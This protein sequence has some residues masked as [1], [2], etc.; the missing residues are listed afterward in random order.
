MNIKPRLENS[1][2]PV[3]KVLIVCEG[4]ET[5]PNYF[6]AFRV[7]SSICKVNGTGHNTV[8]LVKEAQ[9]LS[10]IE[11]YREVWCVFDKDSFTE[12]SVKAAYV[13]AQSAGFKI[14]FSNEC[15]ELWYLL[16]YKYLDT[17]V[18]RA[19]Y[20]KQLKKILGS[21]EKNSMAMYDTLLNKQSDAIKHAKKLNA[22]HNVN[23]HPCNCKPFT[24]VYELVERLNRLARKSA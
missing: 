23:T 22:S 6:R 7:A 12:A 24:T 8:S 1:K 20:T 16:H 3:R 18:S 13:L 2:K 14:A 5:E 9:R 15:F 17:Q 4:E 10:K 21:Y 19:E 11:N